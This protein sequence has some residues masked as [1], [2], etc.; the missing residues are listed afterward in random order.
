LARDLITKLCLFRTDLNRFTEYEKTILEGVGYT[1]ASYR[2][3][4]YCSG[5]FKDMHVT[6]VETNNRFSF[7]EVLEP[8]QMIKS[9]QGSDN[10]FFAIVVRP[11]R[12]WVGFR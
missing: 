5:L 4:M 2:Y 3:R 8:N 6:S 1:L 9:L 11:L 12:N 7:P 10:L